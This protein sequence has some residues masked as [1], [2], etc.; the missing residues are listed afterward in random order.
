M[1]RLVVVLGREANVNMDEMVHQARDARVELVILNIGFPMTA[2]QTA[3]IDISMEAAGR[4]ILDLEARICYTPEE[5]AAK[6]RA[7]D[8][9][10]LAV[11]GPDRARLERALQHRP[12]PLATTAPSVRS[13]VHR[14]LPPS[15]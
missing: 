10:V 13:R 2:E 11:S 8:Q 7:D 12:N 3:A 15:G 5:A 6:I 4:G 1:S 14:S 9:V